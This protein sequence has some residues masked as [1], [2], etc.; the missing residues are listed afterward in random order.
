M[1]TKRSP[2]VGY[3]VLIIFLAFFLQTL[4]P[5]SAAFSAAEHCTILIL[6]NNRSSIIII[7]KGAWQ[8]T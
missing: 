8:W 4:Q 6:T 2:G 7:S 5:A 3:V 1:E